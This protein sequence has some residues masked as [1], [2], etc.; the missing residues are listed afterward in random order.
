VYLIVLLHKDIMLSLK[1]V[2]VMTILLLI[3]LDSV[4]LKDLMLIRFMVFVVVITK[5]NIENAVV[6]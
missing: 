4:V 3:L 1:S 2:F 5:M 6:T